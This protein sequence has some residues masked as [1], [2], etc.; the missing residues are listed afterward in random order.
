MG[1]KSDQFWKILYFLLISLRTQLGLLN[2][3]IT[4][5]VDHSLFFDYV[6]KRYGKDLGRACTGADQG[7]GLL[8]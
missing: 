3:E 4:L 2:F 5:K 7:R 1:F 8:V 6:V